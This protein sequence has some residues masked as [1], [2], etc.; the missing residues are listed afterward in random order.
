MRADLRDHAR[1]DDKVGA[2]T[3]RS[4]RPAVQPGTTP[5]EA[6]AFLDAQEITTTGCRRCS[7]EISGINGRYACGNC[8]WVS[9]WS[10]SHTELP[11]A[12]RDDAA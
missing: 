12:P 6:A 5:A 10:E 8:G 1:T 11:T 4:K 3:N 9:H 2:V 7:T